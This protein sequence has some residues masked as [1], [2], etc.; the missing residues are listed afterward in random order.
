M[1]GL[2]VTQPWCEVSGRRFACRPEHQHESCVH[3]S[4]R[5]VLLLIP[6]FSFYFLC[7]SSSKK[8]SLICT[9]MPETPLKVLL[10]SLLSLSSFLSLPCSLSLSL[11]LSV[12]FLFF[13]PPS[14]QTSEPTINAISFRWR[15]KWNSSWESAAAG[16]EQSLSVTLLS[17]RAPAGPQCEHH[18]DL[19]L[20]WAPATSSHTHKHTHMHAHTHKHTHR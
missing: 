13:L 14:S 17:L 19:S 10:A 11:P 20:L 5:W 16:G 8:P 6:Q 4:V 2:D 9:S 12:S 18:R 1:S 15:N 7:C 3:H